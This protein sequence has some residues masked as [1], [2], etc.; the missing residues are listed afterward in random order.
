MNRLTAIF[1]ALALSALTG[2]SKKEAAV[3]AKAPDPVKVRTAVAEARTVE[4]SIMVTGSLLPDETTTVSSEVG[5]RVAKLYFDFGQP[6]KKGD[7]VAE[8]DTQELALQLDRIRAT[9]AQAM[10][11]VGMDPA[12]PEQ[13][14]DSTPMI[15]QAKA[16]MEDAKSKFDNASKLIKTGDVSQ[17]RYY[18]IEKAYRARVAAYEMTVDDFRTQQAGIRSL[19]A[20]VKLSEKRLRDAKII[21][22]FD[23][24]VSARL[25][26]EGQYI[27][28]NVPVYSLVKSW[29]LRLRMDVPES[30]VSEVKVGTMIEF[31]T[32]SV[33]G[34]KFQA[35]VRELNPALDNR[36]R[37]LTAEAR[38]TVNDP[39]LKPGAFAQVRLVVNQAFPVTAIP[40]EAV[41]TVAGLNKFFTIENGKAVERRIPEILGSNGFVEIPRDTVPAGAS[42][43]VSNVPMLTDGAAVTVSAQ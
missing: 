7:L 33:P 21:A 31:T 14:P 38:P 30:A 9:L 19:Q 28:E 37:T 16:Q 10:A 35:V 22:P 29:P 18:E 13:I 12:R 26:A 2:C 8:I 32:E 39:R 23:A 17:E 43:A 42:V 25:V 36:S 41:Y 40:H 1:L 24:T 27:K 11:R 6:V 3:Q 20:D 15:R 4:R 34:A 5:G